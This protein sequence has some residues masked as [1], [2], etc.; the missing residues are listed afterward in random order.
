MPHYERYDSTQIKKS[1]EKKERA[2]AK[3]GKGNIEQADTQFVIKKTNE[4]TGIVIETRYNEAT[5]LYNGNLITARLK[6]GINAV[7]NQTVFPGDIVV[8]GEEKQ[9]ERITLEVGDHIFICTAKEDCI[10]FA[11]Y[12]AY[13]I[14]QNSFRMRYNKRLYH[15]ETEV[16][17]A[18]PEYK[19]F[20]EQARKTLIK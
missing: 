4:T 2:K 10:T 19:K 15:F 1:K 12:E 17:V 8:I 9:G 5:I 3:A 6:K 7:C 11:D 16:D 18:V 13:D 14:T 20:I